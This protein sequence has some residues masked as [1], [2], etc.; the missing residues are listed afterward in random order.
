VAWENNPRTLTL[1]LHQWTRSGDLVR[2][3]RGLYG[4]PE[5]VGNQ[6]EVARALYSPCY[7][8]LE[9]ALHEYGFLPDVTFGFTLVTPKATRVFT[10]PSGNFFYHQIHQNL[11]WGYHPETLMAEPEKALLDFFYLKGAHFQAKTDFWAT[12]R[13]QN[14]GG[15]NF[16]KAK[17][18]VV[19][20]RSKKM[21][22]LLESLEHY[23]KTQNSY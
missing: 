21:M 17:K 11:F 1:Q 9:S 13:V 14:L 10:T 18:V 12:L 4:F 19:R 6:V 20:F 15:L 5:K 2:L 23:G 8:S 7:I 22:Q 16:K 3:K